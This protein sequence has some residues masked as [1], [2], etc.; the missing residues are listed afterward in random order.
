MRLPYA[1]AFV[2]ACV[3]P[4]PDED[5]DGTSTEDQAIGWRGGH[6]APGEVIHVE[7]DAPGGRGSDPW[8][9]HGGSTPLP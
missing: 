8:W 6:E 1:L 5:A 4:N 2:V 3:S 7:G 9:G